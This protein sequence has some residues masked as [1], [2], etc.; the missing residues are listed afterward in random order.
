MKSIYRNSTRLS[1]HATYV[2]LKIFL[3]DKPVFGTY[4]DDVWLLLGYKLFDAC[5]IFFFSISVVLIRSVEADSH[6][7]QSQQVDYFPVSR[8]NGRKRSRISVKGVQSVAIL[9]SSNRALCTAR[10]VYNLLIIAIT[11]C[12]YSATPVH[13]III[14]SF[15]DLIRS[16]GQKFSKSECTV[17]SEKMC[18]R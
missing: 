6:K 4:H 2:R 18:E 8:N 12:H 17:L 5:Q 7:R 15:F 3:I 9:F 16:N 14:L 11:N 1:Y 10:D 13:V